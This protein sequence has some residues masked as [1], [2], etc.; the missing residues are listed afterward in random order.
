MIIGGVAVIA[1][2]GYYQYKD[3]TSKDVEKFIT[4]KFNDDNYS[5]TKSII[6]LVQSTVS[7]I[8]S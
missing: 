4:D 6:D 3:I 1:A 7:I 5:R 8:C 2:I